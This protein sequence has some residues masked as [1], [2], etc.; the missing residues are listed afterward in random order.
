MIGHIL[1]VASA[2]ALLSPPLLAHG[3][4][5]DKNGCH[6]NRSTGD[7][8]CHGTPRSS[9]AP[10]PAY[11]PPSPAPAPAPR[12]FS[13]EAVPS[14]GGTITISRPN[15]T[16]A[17]LIRAAQHLLGALGHKIGPI[18]GTMTPRTIAALQS[19][20]QTQR[21]PLSVTLDGAMLEKLAE[22]VA[23]SVRP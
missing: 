5:L 9:S 12:L 18:T 1:L 3:G 22:S 14:G 2:A 4:G 16:E 20:Q 21:L 11:S 15:V 6:T 10:A 17:Q 8:H 23:I 7:Y 19:F 13:P